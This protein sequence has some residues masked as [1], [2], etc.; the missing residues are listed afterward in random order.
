[1]DKY[2]ILITPCSPIFTSGP[3]NNGRQVGRSTGGLVWITH[4]LLFSDPVNTLLSCW[5]PVNLSTRVDM[6]RTKIGEQGIM[7]NPYSFTCRPVNLFTTGHRSRGKFRRARDYGKS[8]KVHLSTC[9][10]RLTGPE[11]FIGEQ[12]IMG[13]LY[14]FPCRAVYQIGEQGIMSNPYPY[15]CRPVNLSTTVDRSRGKFRRA[16]DYG[17][18]VLV[19]LSACKPF[20]QG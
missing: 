10:P 19:H 2:G 8:I 1:M 17:Y 4:K 6:S 16:R 7:G 5:Q 11:V 12:G 15:T 3:V 20:Y 9:L 14:V 18:S 13:I